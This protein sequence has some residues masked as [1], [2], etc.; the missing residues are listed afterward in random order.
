M[1]TRLLTIFGTLAV[2]TVIAHF[3]E[4]P[5][6]AQIRAALVQNV[7]EP[8]RNSLSMHTDTLGAS[9][10]FTTPPGKKYVIEAFTIG[11]DVDA[12]SYMTDVS[13][14][15]ISDGVTIQ[16]SAAPHLV[17]PNGS[18]SGHAVNSWR[19]SGFTRVYADPGS[20]IS[21][22]AFDPTQGLAERDCH[23]SIAGYTIS[24]P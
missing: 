9:A 8:G 15:T 16:T 24:N 19:G 20:T 3:F 2:L 21:M 14:Y 11:C 5:I 1:K 10:S 17:Q 4:K 12:T 23:F 13:L 22:R 7:D 6:M 18:V